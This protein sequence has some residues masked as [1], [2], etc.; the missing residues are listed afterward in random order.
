MLPDYIVTILQT[1]ISTK[2]K[3]KYNNEIVYH[4]GEPFPYALLFIYE[5]TNELQLTM[6]CY[7]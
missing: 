4:N 3:D 1:I 2:Y 6:K 7:S 5:L